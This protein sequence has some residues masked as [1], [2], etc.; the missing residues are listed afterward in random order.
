MAR[1]LII[2]F[3]ALGDVAMTV[4]VLH[5]LAVQYPEHEITLLSRAPWQPLFEG[6]PANVRFVGA[7]LADKHKGFLGL[8]SYMPSCK[9]CVSTMWPTS[10]MYFVLN[11]SL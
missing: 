2:R 9:R 8:N 6:L 10:T 1:I 5:S 3:S 7:H 11:I 4:P